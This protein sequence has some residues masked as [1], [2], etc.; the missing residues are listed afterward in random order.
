MF[1]K[2]KMRNERGAKEEQIRR[3]YEK[4]EW[5]ACKQVSKDNCNVFVK[6]SAKL[7]VFDES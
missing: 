7:G 5:R 4:S 3:R 1:L 6:V 2:Q